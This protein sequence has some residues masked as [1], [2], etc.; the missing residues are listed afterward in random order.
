MVKQPY[1][2][3]AGIWMYPTLPPGM[4]AAT[5]EDFQVNGDLNYGLHYLIHSYYSDEFEAHIVKPGFILDKIT[6][7][8]DDNRIYVKQ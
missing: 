5:P 2:H 3:E 1:K 6:P 8:L 7:W 4:R